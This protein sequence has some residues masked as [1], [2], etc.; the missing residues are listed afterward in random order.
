M[1]TYNNGILRELDGRRLYYTFMAGARK[2]ISSQA[3][4]N[5]I[6]VFP[7]NDGDTGTNLAA[8]TRAVIESLLP[9]RSYKVTAERIAE[10]VLLNAR[11]NSGIIFAQFFYGLSIETADIKSITLSEFAESVK[12]AVRY[13]YEA[14]TNPVE[15]TM[16]TVI[17]EWADYI[18]AGRQK[19]TDFNQMLLSSYEVL[20]RSLEE[21]RLK[22]KVLAKNR[23]VDAGAKGFV[24]FIEGIIEFINSRNLKELLRSRYVSLQLPSPEEIIAE[25]VKYRYCT[26]AVIKNVSAEKEVVKK[27]LLDFG[28]S[29]VLAGSKNMM[30]I[31]VHTDNPADLIFRLKDLGTVTFQ[32]ADD[33]IRQ[34]DSVFRRK[35]P[36]AL[37]VDSTCDIDG[38]FIEKYQVH[39]IPVNIHFGENQFLDKV[40]IRPEQFYSM[41][42]SAREYPKSSQAN[43]AAFVNTFSHL[44]SHYDSVI[45]VTLSEKLS[46]TWQSAVKAARK[47]SRESG[48]QISVINSKGISGMAG[49]LL[50]RIAE[51]VEKGHSHQEI[52]KMSEK[53]IENSRLFIRVDTIKY[54]IKGGR[55]SF[56]KGL[57]ARLLNINPLLTLDEDGKVAVLDKAFNRSSG[58]EKIIKHIRNHLT[59]RKTWNY[60][61][62]HAN[63]PGDAGWY[64]AKMKEL[65]GRDPLSVINI[66]P[67]IGLHTGSGGSAVALM[68][69]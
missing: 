69:E 11:G 34:S 47:V 44:A 66:S 38:S 43:E 8:T 52:V 20:C 50:A 29:A 62:L 54:L 64:T 46:G 35:F 9:H 41:L 26:E 5:R 49:L 58:L 48:K 39:I 63:N 53:W 67:V 36:V 40:T 1:I 16:L 57:I 31:H 37:V 33:M 61:V 30:R 18:Y 27:I 13:I 65:T 59:G 2:L 7:V 23:V 14:V 55:L 51:S 3:E 19:F 10:A 60:I 17:R 25:E 45:A 42:E 12:R 21:T 68:T 22:L 24:L 56:I 6:N 28:D 15:G 32:K 4:L